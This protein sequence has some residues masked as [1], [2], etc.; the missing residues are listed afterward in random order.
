MLTDPEVQP[1][2]PRITFNPT[3]VNV[4]ENYPVDIECY[5]SGSVPIH[6]T[7][8]RLDQY[9]SNDIDIRDGHLRFNSIKKSDEGD[10]RC[11]ATNRD[12]D[13]SQIIHVYVNERPNPNPPTDLAPEST[14]QPPTVKLNPTYLDV[15]ENYPVDI[16]C[17]ASGSVPIQYSWERLGDDISND[18]KISE[19]Y[20]RFNSIQ[21]SD[22]GEYSCSASNSYGDDYQIIYVHV[23]VRRNP[24]L[25]TSTPEPPVHSEPPKITLNSTY[26]EVEEND[27]VDIVCAS[28]G[29]TPIQY[30]WERIGAD[31][32]QDINIRDN[33]LRFYSIQKSDEGD[34]SCSARNSYG[35]D[36]QI[37][38]VY[39]NEQSNSNSPTIAPQP[40]QYPTVEIYPP[41]FIG[42]PGD[43][44][45]LSCRSQPEG[46]WTKADFQ[47]L[48][49]HIYVSHGE[50][51]INNAREADSGVYI[52]TSIGS[53]GDPSTASA[54]V[55]IGLQSVPPVISR[56][57]QMYNITQG[58]DFTLNCEATGNPL[59]KIK[60]TRD[61]ESF[62]ENTQQSGNSLR[63]FNAR[64]KN[65]GV[66]TCIAESEHESTQESTII[67][68]ERKYSA[69][70]LWQ[71]KNYLS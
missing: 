38:R 51:V 16:E 63:I 39:V 7:W 57:E 70:N 34:Y 27:P 12:G 3:Y 69:S 2:P 28:A 50:L 18:I 31:I 64:P 42:R 40:P 15:G 46:T 5:S 66:Y 6:Y 36:S 41:K 71:K 24:N 55:E 23:N 25:P 48:P 67:D 13:D 65:R 9:I 56:L 52:C 44:V 11:S 58:H 61:Q 45:R 49:N 1:K 59:P 21:K 26:V 37:I 4:E 8:D 17:T 47:Y 35:D 53:N 30:S 10:Y 14:V 43:E 20:L 62:D 68:V 22:Q 29:S 19:G 33:H 60:W 54:I 32:S